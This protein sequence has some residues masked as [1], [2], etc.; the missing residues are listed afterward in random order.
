MMK[1]QFKKIATLSL[2]A[3][4]LISINVLANTNNTND[5]NKKVIPG[6]SALNE[7]KVT[8]NMEFKSDDPQV[9]QQLFMFKGS[10]MVMAFSENKMYTE[11]NTGS[12]S[13]TVTVT[14][15]DKNKM[16][17]AT[18]GMIGKKAAIKDNLS[19]DSED[20]V[21]EFTK[22]EETKEILGYS[23]IKYILE[24]DEGTQTMWV[25]EAIIPQVQSGNFMNKSVKGMPLEIEI[26][27]P[28]I[29]IV[30]TAT[31]VVE[32]LSKKEVKTLFDL[33]IPDG[34]EKVEFEELQKMGQQ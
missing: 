13:K 18:S 22:T 31:E 10:S 5:K 21:D 27:Q 9:K 24:T 23:C 28:Q 32:E 33:S 26:I 11:T 15:K 29:S 3:F 6:K 34:Y 30:L 8:F 19:D 16:L 4:T 7:A 14:D 17:I 25:T 1:K 12:I 20:T 2:F